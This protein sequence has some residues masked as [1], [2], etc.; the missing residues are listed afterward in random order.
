MKDEIWVRLSAMKDAGALMEIDALVWTEM[1]TPAKIHWR[2]R[3]Q[4]LQSCPP[5]SQLVAGIGEAICGYVGFG[6]P[7]GLPSNAHVY[8]INI[9]VH[10]DHQHKGIGRRLIEEI[11][12]LAK[13]EGKRKLSLRVLETNG[14]AIA[15]YKSCGFVEQGRLVEEFYIGG[16][17]VDDILMW[18]PVETGGDRS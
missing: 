18:C 13:L 2:S 17:Y 4:F 16:R 9:A 12:Y 15:F 14:P 5:G 8:D 11:K 3:E 10:P 6:A 7:T 1:T